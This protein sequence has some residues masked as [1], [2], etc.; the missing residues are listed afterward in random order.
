MVIFR[1]M[2]ADILYLVLFCSAIKLFKFK[3][4]KKQ[5]ERIVYNVNWVQ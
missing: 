3:Q 2:H 1:M 5:N 4:K